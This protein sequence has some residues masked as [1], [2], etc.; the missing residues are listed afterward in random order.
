MLKEEEEEGRMLGC[1]RDVLCVAPGGKEWRLFR[2]EWEE[3]GRGG[4]LAWARMRGK[5]GLLV[6][7][8]PVLT[9]DNERPRETANSNDCVVGRM[10][11][12]EKRREEKRETVMR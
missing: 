3:S 5:W 10:A 8:R 4:L 7:G 2:G 9:D 12:E 6:L 1:R 11:K